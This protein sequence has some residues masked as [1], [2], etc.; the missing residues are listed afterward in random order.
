MN[1]ASGL[2]KA[3]G[4]TTDPI[5]S[6]LAMTR[7]R[8]ALLFMAGNFVGPEYYAGLLRAGRA[9]NIVCNVGRI[10]DASV[11][12]ERRRTGS[13]WNPPPLPASQKVHAFASLRETALLDLIRD[14][15]IDICIQAGIGILR[16]ELLE[17]PKIGWLNVHP[18]KLP[19]YRGNACPEWAI[20]NDDEV[21]ATAHLIDDGIDTGPI[22]TAGRYEFD[23]N[24][25]YHRFR[26]GIYLHCASVL[27]D[28]LDRLDAAGVEGLS[29]VLTAQDQAR[30]V[31][32][33]KIP[34]EF[35]KVVFDKL[36]REAVRQTRPNVER[37]RC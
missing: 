21:W 31:Y 13:L 9:P 25:G 24:G 6:S 19:E 7:F 27:V 17:A 23:L 18:G 14:N 5:V 1:T 29:G 8:T 16:G 3:C 28:A 34:A 15:E 33:P 36:A 30:G 26:A 37:P 12:W 4:I 11:T 2:R 20:F 22:V 32:Y 10:S 35:L